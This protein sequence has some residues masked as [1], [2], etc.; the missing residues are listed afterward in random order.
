[1]DHKP[2]K[3]CTVLGKRREIQEPDMSDYEVADRIRMLLRHHLDHERWCTAGRDRIYYLSD[4]VKRLQKLVSDLQENADIRIP[5]A[6]KL[7]PGKY[8]VTVNSDGTY[9]VQFQKPTN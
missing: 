3:F 2:T 9:S 7:P 8:V 5:D 4:E 6:E 1:M